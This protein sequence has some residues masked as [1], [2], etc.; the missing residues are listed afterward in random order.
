MKSK[1]R[2]QNCGL[3]K[4][5]LGG[6]KENEGRQAFH[7]VMKAFGM[8]EFALTH[9][10]RVQGVISTR[11]KAEARTRKERA[12]KVLVHNQDFKPL[13]TPLRNQTIGAPT[14]PTIPQLQL[15]RGT[16]QGTI[17]GWHPSFWIL[18]T[19]RRTLFCILVCTRSIGSRTA[20]SR[21]QKDALYYGITTEFPL[22]IS[23]FVFAN[24]EVG[25]LF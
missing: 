7:R 16:L 8:V 1:H 6:P 5:V 11:T 23:L 19:I 10:K 14:L 17:H 9:Q 24:S 13:K 21:L 3:K 20:I 25:T 18:P 4:I 12:R 22:A 15:Q 2:N